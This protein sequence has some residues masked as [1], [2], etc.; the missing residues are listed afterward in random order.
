MAKLTLLFKGEK[1]SYIELEKKL[2]K[3]EL[4]NNIVNDGV[5]NDNSVIDF[6][7]KENNTQLH[8]YTVNYGNKN[9]LFYE[10]INVTQ[11]EKGNKKY[12]DYKSVEIFK[13]D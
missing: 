3:N 8:S 7:N 1:I 9:Y 5:I 12:N 4:I 6:Y 2:S 10:T 13:I 11:D